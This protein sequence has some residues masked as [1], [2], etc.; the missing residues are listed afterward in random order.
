MEKGE[1]PR[2][3][4]VSTDGIQFN[5]ANRVTLA[6]ILDRPIGDM[7]GDKMIRVREVVPLTA[8]EDLVILRCRHEAKDGNGV[9][10]DDVQFLLDIIDKLR[11]QGW[12]KE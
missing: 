8:E 1:K 2:E 3:W 11:G 12:V 10:D 9:P 7:T 5:G 6:M 4:L